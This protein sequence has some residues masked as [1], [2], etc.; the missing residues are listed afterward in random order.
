MRPGVVSSCYCLSLRLGVAFHISWRIR[1]EKKGEAKEM[2]TFHSSQS[3]LGIGHL[4]LNVRRG[5]QS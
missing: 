5:W 2:R 3:L 4:L 1:G